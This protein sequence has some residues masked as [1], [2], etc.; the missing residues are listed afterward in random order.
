MIPMPV[1][2][3]NPLNNSKILTNEPVLHS[4]ETYLLIHLIIMNSSDVYTDFNKSTA[5]NEKIKKYNEELVELNTKWE[6]LTNLII[7][8]N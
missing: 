4:K 1:M 5:I 2:E 3:T 7:N 8:S 6:E